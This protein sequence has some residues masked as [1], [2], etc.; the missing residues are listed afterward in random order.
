ML[1]R[2]IATIRPRPTTTSDAA[3]AITEIA[4]IWPSSRPCS[5]ANAI[6]SRFAAFSMISTESRMISGDRRSI[7]P[8]APVANSSPASTTYALMSG[9]CIRLLARMRAQ[10]D[11][12]DGGD[13]QDDRRHLEREQVVGEEELADVLRRAEAAVDLRLVRQEPAGAQA[14]DDDHLGEQRAAREDGAERL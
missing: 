7:T 12:A 8:S 3:I 1:R 13:E 5:R 6:S 14:D 4:K 2:P 9:P 10:H 11:A